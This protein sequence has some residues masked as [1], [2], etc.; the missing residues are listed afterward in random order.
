MKHPPPPRQHGFSLLELLVAF[1][2]MALSLGMLYQATGGSTRGVVEAER[3][4]RAALLAQS[5]LAMRDSVA[6][7]GWNEAGE[8]AGYAWQV[9]SAPHATGVKDLKAPPLHE[10]AITIAWGHDEQARQLTLST[11]RPQRKPPPGGVI[12]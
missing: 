7:E 6:E 10:V 12:R 5:L 11:L 3:Y 1:S 4:Q 8:S 2:I 9:R